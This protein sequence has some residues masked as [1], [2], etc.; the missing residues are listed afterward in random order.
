[1]EYK[2]LTTAL[3]FYKFLNSFKGKHIYTITLNLRNLI[4]GNNKNK[5][6]TAMQFTNTYIL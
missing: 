6:L 3:H 4:K 5:L 1:M 2:W